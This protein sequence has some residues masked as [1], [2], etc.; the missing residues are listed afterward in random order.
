MQPSWP[1]HWAGEAES[2]AA[3][4][5]F[6]ERFDTALKYAAQFGPSERKLRLQLAL[7]G[8]RHWDALSPTGRALTE[9]NIDATLRVQP[10]T[11]LRSAFAIRREPLVCERWHDG[12]DLA[13]VCERG[14]GLRA[15]CDRRNLDV[16]TVVWCLERGATPRYPPRRTPR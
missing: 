12:G 14:R 8:M 13:E 15:I 7:L 5:D 11:L 3:A 1:Y 4:R 6:S 2:L 10:G 9:D 16:D